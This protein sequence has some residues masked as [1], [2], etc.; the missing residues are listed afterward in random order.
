MDF[1][2]KR[3]TEEE[4]GGGSAAIGFPVRADDIAALREI[5]RA[6]GGKH[7]VKARNVAISQYRAL[8]IEGL[9]ELIDDFKGGVAAKLTARA[10]QALAAAPGMAR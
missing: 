2:A 1:T 10:L 7:H 3:K 6:G 8:R 9:V 4:A 5:A